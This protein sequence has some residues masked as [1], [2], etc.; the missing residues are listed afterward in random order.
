MECQRG[1][2]PICPHGVRVPDI[3]IAEFMADDPV[4]ALEALFSV[5]R[6]DGLWE[7]PD[8]LGALLGNA[9]GLIVRSKAQVTEA[10]L[11]RAPHLKVIGRLGVG[12][13]NIDMDACKARGIAVCPATGANAAAV[14]EY[15]ITSALVLL[16]GAFGAAGKIVAGEWPREKLGS[17][18]ELGGCTF[19]IVGFGN[20]GQETARRA[21]AFGCRVI[22]HDPVPGDDDPAWRLAERTTFAGLIAEADVISLHVPLLE[23]TRNL[24]DAKFIGQMKSGA[25]LINTARGG[26]VDEAALGEALRNGRVGGAALDVFAAEPPSPGTLEIFSGLTNVILTPH[27]AGLSAQANARVSR[28]TVDNVLAVLRG[29]G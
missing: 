25:I 27:I 8:Q 21:A 2:T 24:I 19:G 14:A 22:A 5:H 13:D 20:I 9:K 16:R 18:R 3:V 17:G 6:D 4:A 11:Q 10:L 1:L 7:Y 26:I 29:D 28:V 12:L 23:A 15:S